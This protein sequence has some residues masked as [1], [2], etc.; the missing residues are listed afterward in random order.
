MTHRILPRPGGT[1]ASRPRREA[2]VRGEENAVHEKMPPTFRRVTQLNFQAQYT[3]EH[4]RPRRGMTKSYLV[5]IRQVPI[6][7][8]RSGNERVRIRDCYFETAGISSPPAG[9]SSG[10]QNANLM[11]PLWSCQPPRQ[12]GRLVF[13]TCLRRRRQ[14]HPPARNRT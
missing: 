4:R 3:E 10:L 6:S 5:V 7:P 1:D 8:L 9:R 14:S 13:Y 11:R 12:P 2:N